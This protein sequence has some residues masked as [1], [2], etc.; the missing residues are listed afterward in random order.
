MRRLKI[1]DFKHRE[2]AAAAR[3]ELLR[4][5]EQKRSTLATNFN[6]LLGN[7]GPPDETADEMIEA[8]REW[9]SEGFN[10]SG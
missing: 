8:I 5:V 1:Q 7:G 9:R 2:E 10:A 6:D 3:A 4:L